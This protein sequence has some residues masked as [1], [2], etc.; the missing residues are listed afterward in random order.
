MSMV[1]GLAKHFAPLVPYNRSAALFQLVIL[2]SRSIV[3]M[4]SMLDQRSIP[5][6]PGIF[7]GTSGR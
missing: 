2:P 1:I 3:I 4:E 7:A 5:G 6:D